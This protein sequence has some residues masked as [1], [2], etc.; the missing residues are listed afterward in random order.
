MYL[1][2]YGYMSDG[3]NQ[4]R[5]TTMT[6]TNHPKAARP[7]VKVVPVQ[8]LTLAARTIF[9]LPGTGRK[10]QLLRTPSACSA[11]CRLWF[12]NKELEQM[13]ERGRAT[14]AYED[15]IISSYALVVPATEQ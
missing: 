6:K 7:P 9:I 4:P 5:T 15:T 8:L 11:Y 3:F 10:G 13:A 2:L 14:K 12:L 1:Q